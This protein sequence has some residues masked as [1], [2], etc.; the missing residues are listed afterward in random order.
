MIEKL[1]D[2]N[3][4]NIWNYLIVAILSIGLLFLT[5]YVK[6]HYRCQEMKK[7]KDYFLQFLRYNETIDECINKVKEK[8]ELKTSQTQRVLFLALI[9]GYVGSL[10]LFL[11]I[12]LIVKDW[13]LSVSILALINIL[14]FIFIMIYINWAINYPLENTN[15]SFKGFEMIKYFIL[16][17][18]LV[19]LIT[20]QSSYLS[21]SEIEIISV[22]LF[23][24]S[25]IFLLGTTYVLIKGKAK[26]I[27]AL[28]SSLNDLYLEKFPNICIKVIDVDICGKITNIFDENLIIL[29]HNGQKIA[30]EWDKIIAIRLKEKI[31][32][33]ELDV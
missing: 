14:P 2:F 30:V 20:I 4:D 13:W 31:I 26:V 23:T 6:I 24:I 19:I 22:F 33:S 9:L 27:F 17:S 12:I 16:F 28:K 29:Y 7:R 25:F 18:N 5:Q 3:I 8:S 15:S 10:F 1:I 21:Q 11:I 32:Q